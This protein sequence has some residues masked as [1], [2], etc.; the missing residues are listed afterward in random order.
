MFKKYIESYKALESDATRSEKLKISINNIDLLVNLIYEYRSIAIDNIDQDDEII[1]W[2]F[3]D[4]KEDLGSAIWNLSCALYKTSASCLR[5]A[6]EMSFVSLYFNI[7]EHEHVKKNINEK[8][9]PYNKFFADWDSGNKDT[10]NWGEMMPLIEKNVNVKNFNKENNCDIMRE[11]Y[12]W[13]KHLCSFTHGKSFDKPLIDL[14]ALPTNHTNIGTEF[15]EINFDRFISDFNRT[16]ST[17]GTFWALCF[18]D[19]LVDEKYE[20]IFSSTREIEILKFI[21]SNR[22]LVST[23]AT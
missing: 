15:T 9:I 14:S 4:V 12:S 2:T 11:T 16:I 8:Y 17:I 3:E 19:I 18:P 10:P 22:N 7:R 21:K 1:N 23:K 20:S 13:F 6:F 5:N